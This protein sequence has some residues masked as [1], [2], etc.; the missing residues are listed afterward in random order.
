MDSDGG[1]VKQLVD[2]DDL[3]GDAPSWSPDGRRIAIS[4]REGNGP[5]QIFLI[6]VVTLKRTGLPS[7][8]AALYPAWCPDGRRIAFA[9]VGDTPEGRRGGIWITDLSGT[10]QS[11]VT[12]GFVHRA[13]PFGCQTVSPYLRNAR[14]VEGR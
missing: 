9:G 10:H 13:G 12:N 5:T 4:A 6:D 1:N 2:Q 14:R 8:G 7:T 3:K 11:P